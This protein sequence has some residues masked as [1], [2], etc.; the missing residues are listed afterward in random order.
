MSDPISATRVIRTDLSAGGDGTDATI[1]AMS[2]AAM[3][4]YGA[5][6]GRVIAAAREIIDDAGVPERDQRGEVE[7]IHRFVMLHLRYVRD[8]LWYEMITY[9]ET[10]LFDTATGDC[11]DH[12]VLEAALL[13]ALGIPTRF[14]TYGFKGN[15]A[16]SHVAMEAKVGSEWIPLDPIVKDKPAGWSVPDASNVTRYGVNTPSGTIGA[17]FSVVNAGKMLACVVA[18]VAL[19]WWL[20]S[21]N[22]KRRY[23]V[24]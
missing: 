24:R 3:G 18:G 2:R 7:A 19:W 14:V 15:I 9:P 20:R 10:L 1:Q 11:D 5:G 21:L 16:Q 22:K 6:S 23:Y 4:E 8:P 17:A 13:G 12:V